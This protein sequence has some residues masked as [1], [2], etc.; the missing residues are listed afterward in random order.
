MPEPGSPEKETILFVD[1]EQSILDIAR[2]YFSEHGYRV[3]TAANGR[4]AIEKLEQFDPVCCFTDINMPEMDG[5]E[6][7]EYVRKKD[8][9]IPVVIMTGY[10]SLENTIRTLKNGVVDFL[11]KPVNLN[12]M[13]LCLKRVLRERELFIKN[14]ILR[15]ELEGKKRIEAVNRRLSSKVEEL[16]ILNRIM[17]GLMS[18][19]S[20]SEFFKSMVRIAGEVT[21][22][23]YTAFFL[24][25]GPVDA[26]V[27]VA[28]IDADEYPTPGA[29]SGFDDRHFQQI[30]QE[31]AADKSPLLL[32][33]NQTAKKLDPGVTSFA[34]APLMIRDGNFGVLVAAMRDGS[35]P[36]SEKHLYYMSFL[37]QQASYMVENLA[38]YENIC[39][40]LVATLSA[41]VK[42]VEARDD[43][44]NLH[45]TRVTEIAK[46][47]A[48]RYGCPPAEIE[49]L[50][51]AGR[52]H[53]VGKIGVRDEILLKPSVLSSLEYEVI[54]GHPVI[55]E[56][57]IDQ[58]GLWE[59]EKRVIRHHHE[60]FDGTGYPDGLKG[61]EIPLLS[62]ILSVADVFDAMVSERPYRKEIPGDEVAAFMETQAGR[63]FDPDIVRLFLELYRENRFDHI[64]LEKSP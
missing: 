54:K 37:A 46:I 55:G 50:D 1:D 32:P 4:Q 6:F 52:L 51:F 57:I 20:G 41:L 26:P 53:D 12:Q 18:L 23:D 31:I 16:R 33:D 8:N 43:Y 45:S 49:A 21:G 62:R 44:T 19:E 13:S 2:E 56:G 28:A 59:R 61:E 11:I 24:T 17:T 30:V 25:N 7:A 9:T 36:L 10:P 3:V 15:K 39:E 42:T 64:Y 35:P 47:I 27:R 40:N 22:A 14:V 29:P 63:Q 38:L 58:L 5:L 48:G 34:G 60:W